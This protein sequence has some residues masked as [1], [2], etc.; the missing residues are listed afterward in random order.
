MQRSTEYL[1]FDYRL[2]WC[3]K[4]TNQG[5]PFREIDSTTFHT[6]VIKIIDLFRIQQE[7]IR[8]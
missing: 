5:N 4:N 8:N 2:Y 1:R 6:E 7:E 3:D